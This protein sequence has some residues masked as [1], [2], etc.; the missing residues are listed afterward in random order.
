MNEAREREFMLMLR[1][2]LMMIVSWIDTT[3][4]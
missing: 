3:Y 4:R 1:R 2:A